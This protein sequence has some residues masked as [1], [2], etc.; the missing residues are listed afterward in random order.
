[1]TNLLK[2]EGKAARPKDGEPA[3]TAAGGWDCSPRFLSRFL[4][5]SS[6]A[7]KGGDSAAAQSPGV[8]GWPPGGGGPAPSRHRHLYLGKQGGR[9]SS[10]QSPQEPLPASLNR[11]E[12]VKAALQV[13]RTRRS[14]K[15]TGTPLEECG[16][17]TQLS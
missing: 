14:G 17:K 3:G 6:K 5:R 11:A 15:A 1:M 12:R 16:D 7:L 10:S 4:S 9:G 2:K 13:W 8:S